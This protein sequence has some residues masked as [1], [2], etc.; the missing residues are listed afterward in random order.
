[1]KNL[2]LGDKGEN[3][4]VLSE[5][6]E[7]IIK[8]HLDWRLNETNDSQKLAASKEE[9][10]ELFS[11]LQEMLEELPKDIPFFSQRYMAQ[12]LKSPSIPSILAYLTFLIHNPN[13]HAY[14]GGPVTTKM[15]LQVEQLFLTMI[16]F[17][18]GW[19]HLTNGGTIA[20]LEALW[21]VRESKNH[22]TVY[23]S[24]ASHFA[25]SRICVVLNVP[26]KVIPVD[27][28][29]RM[30]LRELEKECQK[31][32]PLMIVGNLGSTGTGSVDCLEEL[33]SFRENFN[34]HFHIDGAYGGFTKTLIIG[35]NGSLIEPVV[36]G[37][38]SSD[39]MNKIDNYLYR[40]LVAVAECDSI[41]IDPHKQGLVS[42]GAGAIFFK[43]KV[44]QEQALHTAPY[45]YN[46]TEEPNIG[47]YCLEGSR[48]GA[49]AA[50]CYLTYKMFPLNRGGMGE[51]IAISN[52]QAKKLYQALNASIYFTPLLSPDLDILVF[53]CI[54][55]PEEN[56]QRIYQALNVKQKEA[57]WYISKF[58]M[59]L[60]NS[61]LNLKSDTR[62]LPEGK[63]EVLR[64]V[65]M[66]PWLDDDFA[67]KFVSDL[68]KIL[69]KDQQ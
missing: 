11:E 56:N 33:I 58:S 37:E 63:I 2:F 19:G 45:T 20:N 7:M 24:E 43:D 32:S 55:M 28:K 13:N 15:E 67:S 5:G 36:S 54:D 25:W 57:N 1:M 40:Q 16:G 22:G 38:T 6:I 64:V 9:K 30:D 31:E 18:Q 35:E 17:D 23:F 69:R 27:E 12:M 3:F 34:A 14:E 62:K 44:Y 41:T 51:L 61:N 47:M 49:M 60:K 59:S 8:S 39:P 21:L 46:H 42:Y 50:S 53:S 52:Y 65:L 29:Y 26:Y 48:A 68:E 66:K 4:N 10:E